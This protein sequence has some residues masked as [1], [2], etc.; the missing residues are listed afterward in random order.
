MIQHAVHGGDSFQRIGVDFRSL[1]QHDRVIDADVLD[2]WYPPAPGVTEKIAAHLEWLI[3]TSPPTHADGLVD[4]IAYARGVPRESVLVG[5]GSS[6]L[7]F[8]ALPHLV[9][10][11]GHATILDPMYG[12]YAHVIENVIGA[13]LRRCHLHPSLDFI[14][15]LDEL[16]ASSH[17]ADLVVLVNPNSPTGVGVGPDFIRELLGRLDS[18]TM[19]WVDETYIDFLGPNQSVECLVA[20]D[21]RLIVSKSMS[22]VYALSGLR[23]GYLIARPDRVREWALLS[24]PWGV[25]LIAQVA[26]VEALAASDYYA[27]RFEE[28]S[29]L[30]KAM[31]GELSKFVR[32]IPGR[33]NFLLLELEHPN[34]DAIVARCAEHDVFLRNC[35][36]LSERFHGRYLRTAVKDAETN[37]RI[38]AALRA[39]LSAK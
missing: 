31:A 2:A 17:G 1:D 12:E 9:R 36:S 8:L 23:L 19:L 6:T 3:K 34:A 13:E 39:A 16:A 33:A 24:P 18:N 11:G 38:I 22:K 37:L 27:A 20:E 14:P 4:A 32:V 5:A 26:G 35:D 21:P 10:R 7:I 28:T 25:G 30:R 29:A 15:D